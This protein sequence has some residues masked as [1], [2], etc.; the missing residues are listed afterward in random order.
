MATAAPGERSLHSMLGNKALTRNVSRA[1]FAGL[2][3]GRKLLSELRSIRASWSEEVQARRDSGVW[4]VA[5]LLPRH[6]VVNATLVAAELGV[7]QPNVYR[8]LDR[9]EHAGVLVKS[10]VQRRNKSWRLP[11]ILSALDTL[12]ST[13][14]PAVLA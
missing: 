4:R 11:E 10:T 14:E 8:F 5:D 6:P 7:A 12:R 13:S 2:I 1:V 9:L 3:N